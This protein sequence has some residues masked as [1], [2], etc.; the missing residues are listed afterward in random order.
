MRTSHQLLRRFNLLVVLAAAVMLLASVFAL[1]A[2]A[3][4]D[5]VTVIELDGTIT[6][7]MADFVGRALDG[8]GDRN[9]VVVIQMDTPG[10]LSSA[11]DDI[12]S[13]ILAASVPVIVWVGPNGARAA[14]AGV[15]IT[16]AAH[17][18]TMAPA[19]NIGSATPISLGEDDSEEPD[20]ASDR[21]VLND[22]IGKI[23]GLAE[24][25]GRNVEWAEDAVRNAANVSAE[26]ALSLGV[27]DLVASSIPDLLE[28]LDGRDVTV[29]GETRTL[30][31]A[32]AETRTTRMNWIEQF[33]Q[34]VS[35][36]NIAFLFVSIGTLALIFELANPGAIGPGAIG[37]LLLVT[38]FYSLGTLDASW[39]A[40][41]LMAAAGVILAI[42]LLV[43]PG[44]GILTGA[45][46]TTFVVG[47]VLL[48]TSDSAGVSLLLV[49][50]VG[51]VLAVLVVLIVGAAWRVRK[52]APATG[53]GT[54][55]G[56]YA[57]ARSP[58][59]PQGM[60][61]VQGELWNARTADGSTIASGTRV[62][63]TRIDGFVLEV[64][65]PDT[66]TSGSATTSEIHTSGAGPAAE[67][68]VP[69]GS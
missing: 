59:D 58:L 22:A 52:K 18:A 36:P 29:A 24:L 65:L 49:L 66:A 62:R 16:Y 40:L 37:V 55:V 14:S 27:I 21:K 30:Q 23:R 54:L 63:V 26:Q 3:A 15:Y 64:R 69:A 28:Q 47:G 34:L 45:G 33:L 42:D 13:D 48:S 6:P 1:P 43:V 10:G 12:V 11:M 61:Y 9:Q 53:T 5:T 67:A 60:V 41:A 46:I 57:E 68:G 17:L 4:D 31:T 51:A 50:G 2:A 20:S 8:A 19:T 38:G 39:A 35:D 56:Q 32:G 44:T 25:R 7:V